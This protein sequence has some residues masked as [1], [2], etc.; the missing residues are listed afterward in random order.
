MTSQLM[1]FAQTTSRELG[2]LRQQARRKLASVKWLRSAWHWARA[3]RYELRWRPATQGGYA[4]C[5]TTRADPWG[6]EVTS[7][8][9]EKFEAAV[10][11]LNGARGG[12]RFKRA[13]EI[14]C[15][16]G[17]MTVRLTQVCERLL[18]VDYIAVALERARVRCGEVEN[19]SFSVWDLKSDPAPGTF[20][21]VVITDVLGSLGGRRDICRARDKVVSAL[22]PG[23]YL[24]YGD[25]LGD[26]TNR[27]IHDSWW[28][29]SLLLRPRKILRLVAAHPTLVEVARRETT[30]HS[31]VLFRTI[32]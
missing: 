3:L 16:E 5:F 19:V 2:S 9:F 12:A 6:Y 17:L 29:R 4:K 10:E 25:F 11:L 20:D 8:T 31:L 26:P 13:W 18:A 1:R 30:M 23:G 28:G 7:F 24:L 27:R 14:G 22:A 15:A 21:L 32:D